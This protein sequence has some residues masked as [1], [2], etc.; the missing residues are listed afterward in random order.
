MAAEQICFCWLY[1]VKIVTLGT[2]SIYFTILL[3]LKLM[4]YVNRTT[5]I[6]RIYS[7]YVLINSLSKKSLK[8]NSTS[9]RQQYNN[10]KEKW[11]SGNKS[12][13]WR[14]Y[15][16]Y[17]ILKFSDINLM[18]LVLLWTRYR[19]LKHASAIKH[20]LFRNQTCRK[21]WEN[22]T[23]KKRLSQKTYP[24]HLDKN[25]ANAN[26]HVCRWK[27]PNSRVLLANFFD[28]WRMDDVVL[29]DRA[30]VEIA[31]PQRLTGK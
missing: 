8:H 2:N 27:V 22:K 7:T 30:V 25:E 29:F 3:V 6:S 9:L 13:S 21:K 16:H 15:V 18:W 14:I 17:Y 12:F 4:L 19:P 26:G 5:Y 20:P 31:C 11:Y 23:S 10:Y 24:G 1:D 28:E